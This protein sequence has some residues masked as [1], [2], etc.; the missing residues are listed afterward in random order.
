MATSCIEEGHILD[1][2]AAGVC[3]SS[4]LQPKSDAFEKT[5]T[6]TWIVAHASSPWGRS[7]AWSKAT[8]ETTKIQAYIVK[9]PEG[10]AYEKVPKLMIV[11]YCT[12]HYRLPIILYVLY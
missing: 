10:T 6:E 5:P 7:Q 11:L 4:L 2:K 9:T 3:N 8:I 1:Q 12:Y